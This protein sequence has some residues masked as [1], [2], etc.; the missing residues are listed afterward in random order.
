MSQPTARRARI[1]VAEDDGALRA[2]IAATLRHAGYEVVEA[3][4][5]VEAVGN[6]QPWIF[7]GRAIEPPDVIVSD[8]R[9]PG[10]SGLDALRILRAGAAAPPVVL[11]TAFG[12][13]ETH[14]LAARLGAAHV[15]DKPFAVE[16]LVAVVD[17]LVALLRLEA[18][19]EP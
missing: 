19:A 1:L 3:G 15:F 14:E 8:I 10:W 13:H 6:A 18:P 12:S 16:D 5:G 9:M 4:D 11:M 17:E 2:L 7:R